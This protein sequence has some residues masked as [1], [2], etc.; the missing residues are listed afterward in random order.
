MESHRHA[1]LPQVSHSHNPLASTGDLDRNQVQE[2]RTPDTIAIV[3]ISNDPSYHRWLIGTIG[4][5]PL[6]LLPAW[7]ISAALRM[8]KRLRP[9]AVLFD[10]NMPGSN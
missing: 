2:S 9:A 8:I 6:A 7:S 1:N 3:T 5:P 4:K 10:D